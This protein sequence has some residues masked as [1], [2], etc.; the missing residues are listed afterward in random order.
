M[1]VLH[2]TSFKIVKRGRSR[3]KNPFFTLAIAAAIAAATTASNKDCYNYD[4]SVIR[5]LRYIKSSYSNCT[6]AFAAANTAFDNFV[7]AK[8]NTALALALTAL[9]AFVAFVIFVALAATVASVALIIVAFFT[10]I[11]A[12]A[13]FAAAPA[14][15]ITFA[16]R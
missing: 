12:L 9:I 4:T 14:V 3:L 7:N 5:Y 15:A 11:V 8:D 6:V 13:A 16:K 10:L 2:N 1:L